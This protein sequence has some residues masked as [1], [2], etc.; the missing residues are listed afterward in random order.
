M[1]IT[2]IFS[3][4]VPQQHKAITLSQ[5]YKDKIAIKNFLND[6]SELNPSSYCFYEYD[7]HYH[8]CRKV[9]TFP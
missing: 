7:Y 5:S 9:F 1:F 6:L 4:L 2:L 3:Y 8:S